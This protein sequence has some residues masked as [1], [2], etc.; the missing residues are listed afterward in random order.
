MNM[1]PVRVTAAVI[2]ILGAA[3]CFAQTPSPP[4]STTSPS[5]ASS[6]SQRDATR[7]P[8]A[9]SPATGGSQ[10]SAASTPHQREA[11]GK[12]QTMKDCMDTQASTNS[13][14]SKS[15]M[16]KA[17]DEQMKKQKDHAHMSKAPANSPN[18]SDSS[19]APAPK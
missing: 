9:E 10:P 17:C 8:A 14:M 5:S 4:T 6:P 3:A 7:S 2:G 1:T 12:P 11:M 13:G 15:D 18:S 16:T 19:Q